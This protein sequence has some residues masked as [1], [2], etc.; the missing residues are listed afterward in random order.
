MAR[1]AMPT[2]P[3]PFVGNEAYQLSMTSS[4]AHDVGLPVFSL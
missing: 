4:M 3:P 2:A 1:P